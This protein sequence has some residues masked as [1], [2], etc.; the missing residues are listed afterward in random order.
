MITNTGRN[1]HKLS[2]C[3]QKVTPVDVV[4]TLDLPADEV[5][6]IYRD[7]WALNDMHELVEV[8]DQTS[9]PSLLIIQNSECGGNG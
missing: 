1:N 7:Y 6:V 2:N 8:Y 4:V 3:F 5:R 9:L